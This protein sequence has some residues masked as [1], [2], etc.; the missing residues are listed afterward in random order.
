MKNNPIQKDPE[1]QCLSLYKLSWSVFRF[2]IK[3]KLNWRHSGHTMTETLVP[4]RSRFLTHLLSSSLSHWACTQLLR[5]AL[6]Q[7]WPQDVWCPCT[8]RNW[9]QQNLIWVKMRTNMRGLRTGGYVTQW[10]VRLASR[11][12]WSNLSIRRRLSKLGED[13]PEAARREN[14]SDGWAGWRAWL[15]TAGWVHIQCF[16]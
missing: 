3:W 10:E 7:K 13:A 12:Q 15:H 6:G 11:R 4:H 2:E 5:P 1:F 8:I 14:G 9:P 16:C